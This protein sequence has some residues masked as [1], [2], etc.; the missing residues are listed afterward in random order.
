MKWWLVLFWGLPN[1]ALAALGNDGGGGG[2]AVVCRDQA[3]QIT[4]AEVLDLFEA[5]VLHRWQIPSSPE[6][7]EDQA[8]RMANRLGDINKYYI[9]HTSLHS[10]LGKARVLPPEY[11]LEP[12]NDSFPV[13]GVKG[14]KIEQLARYLSSDE[15]LIDGEIWAK[16][17]ETNKAA[18]YLHET[19]YWRLRAAG[20][21][22][23]LR[24]R[25]I[26]GYLMNDFSLR[27]PVVPAEKVN[28]FCSDNGYAF[29]TAFGVVLSTDAI[30]NQNATLYFYGLDGRPLV[31]LTTAHVIEG[32]EYFTHPKMGQG[33][34]FT[35]RSGFEREARGE[36]KVVRATHD[37]LEFEFSFDP[38]TK[39]EDQPV[40]QESKVRVSCSTPFGPNHALR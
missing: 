1:F 23:S 32:Q 40:S 10:I 14:C 39:A 28:L 31:D 20:A 11:S 38:N 36:L 25:R 3:G 17:D 33:F 34:G 2:N 9:I 21:T 22:N 18:L 27:A 26:V 15:L 37:H 16:L 19:L 12:V 4:S 24:A 30:G 35:L 6:A 5:R 13:I 8:I 29:S 7:A